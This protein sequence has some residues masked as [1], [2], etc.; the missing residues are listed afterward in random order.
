MVDRALFFSAFHKNEQLVL[1]CPIYNSP[2][3]FTVTSG[4]RAL[5]RLAS[6]VE[7]AREPVMVVIYAAPVSSAQATIFEILDDEGCAQEVALE[8]ITSAATN[9]LALTTLFKD[10]HALIPLF[11]NWYRANGVEQF[12]LYYNGVATDDIRRRCDLPGVVLTDWNF[13]YWNDSSC[14]YKHHAQMGQMHDA[15]YRFGKDRHRYMIFCDLDEYLYYPRGAL[16]ELARGSDVDAVAFRNRWSTTHGDEPLPRHFPMQFR[17]C[18]RLRYGKRSKCM[19]RTSSAVTLHIHT[20]RRTSG[21]SRPAAPPSPPRLPRVDA[22]YDMF[23][24]ASWSRPGRRFPEDDNRAE[25]YAVYLCGGDVIE[26]GGRRLY[27]FAL[28]EDPLRVVQR[29]ANHGE[30]WM[31]RELAKYGVHPRSRRGA[32]LAHQLCQLNKYRG[33]GRAWLSREL[34]KC[35]VCQSGNAYRL[36]P[37]LAARQLHAAAAVTVATDAL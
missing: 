37:L 30:V 31:R 26:S 19:H 16:V 34:A 5:Q 14:K 33:R 9:T 28:A 10:D 15:L 25:A 6:H 20:H 21:T 2:R 22:S 24:F 7:D 27:R 36:A 8:H 4:G 35:G 17:A 3:S 23:H 13:R 18:S 12:Y 11:Y 1:I 32:D 29:A